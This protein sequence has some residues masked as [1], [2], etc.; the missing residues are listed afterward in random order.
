VR[1]AGVSKYKARLE[2]LLRGP[3]QW[4]IEIFEACI[5]ARAGLNERE[6]PG[7]VVTARP[8]KCLAQLCSVSKA[9]DETSKALVKTSK[10]IRF[11]TSEMIG[12]DRVWQFVRN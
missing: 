6:A 9:L 10:L 3:T 11:S 5:K 7:N 2:T 1:R 12:G 8:P 4:C